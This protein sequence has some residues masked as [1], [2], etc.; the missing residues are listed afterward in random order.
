M[1]E[2][3]KR[4]RSQYFLRALVPGADQAVDAALTEAYRLGFAAGAKDGAKS[5]RDALVTSGEYT[6]GFTAGAK[7]EREAAI[8]WLDKQDVRAPLTFIDRPLPE[9]K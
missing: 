8:N 3:L 9:A 1:Q 2:E 6:T 4:L 5:E 7:A